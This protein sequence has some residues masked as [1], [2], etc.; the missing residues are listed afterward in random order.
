MKMFQNGDS[1]LE[2]QGPKDKERCKAAAPVNKRVMRVNENLFLQFGSSPVQWTY[3]KSQKKAAGVCK[4]KR[5]TLSIIEAKRRSIERRYSTEKQSKSPSPKKKKEIKI[6]PHITVIEIPENLQPKKQKSEIQIPSWRQVSLRGLNG[7][8]REEL[9]EDLS[10]SAFEKRHQKAEEEEQMLWEKWT[11]MREAEGKAEGGRSK[12]SR[13]RDVEQ[14]IFTPRLRS[15]RL[16]SLLSDASSTPGRL[17]P[18]TMSMV[19]EICVEPVVLPSPKP[20]S[21][22]TPKSQGEK[23]RRPE[24]RTLMSVLNEVIKEEDQNLRR[25][26]GE[27]RRASASSLQQAAKENMGKGDSSLQEQKG[28]GQESRTSSSTSGSRVL[29]DSNLVLAKAQLS[30]LGKG[31]SEFKPNKIKLHRPSFYH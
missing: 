5:G 7:I 11:E 19:Q 3:C 17:S 25:V 18:T 20:A 27:I 12:S 21:P 23:K 9:E 22:T 1:C 6:I 30:R 15:Q 26:R 4:R 13:W 29:K 14:H 2:T 10:D 31:Q 28:R 16:S 8:K 24:Q